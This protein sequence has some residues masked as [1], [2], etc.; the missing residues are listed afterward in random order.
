MQDRRG[1]QHEHSW[2]RTRGGL[3]HRP[4]RMRRRGQRGQVGGLHVCEGDRVGAGRRRGRLHELDTESGRGRAQGVGQL[5]ARCDHRHRVDLRQRRPDADQMTSL[6]ASAKRAFGAPA[7]GPS[8]QGPPGRSPCSTRRRRPQCRRSSEGPSGSRCAHATR[9]GA[10]AQRPPASSKAGT[11]CP[12]LDA[13]PAPSEYAFRRGRSLPHDPADD[14]D[15]CAAD[16]TRMML[17]AS[18]SLIQGA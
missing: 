4:V 12:I 5:R 8:V 9:S 11:P 2:H 7:S 1:G 18:G 14:I 10:S 17:V 13:R 15:R 3:G 16:L 6:L